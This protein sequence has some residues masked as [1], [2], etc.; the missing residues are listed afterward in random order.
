MIVSWSV[1]VSETV[2][3]RREVPVR[4]M[5]SWS[6]TTT[7]LDGT[8][9]RTKYSRLPPGARVPVLMVTPPSQ[10]P[11]PFV[12]VAITL[13]VTGLSNSIFQPFRLVAFMSN[14]SPRDARFVTRWA[15]TYVPP[16]PE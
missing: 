4:R 5:R 14:E 3:S 10:A 12:S 9:T 15:K 1:A 8:V 2:G 13:P 6:P 16:I 11:S 7:P